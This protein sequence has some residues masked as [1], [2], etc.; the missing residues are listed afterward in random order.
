MDKYRLSEVAKS[1]LKRIYIRG[2]FEFG[3]KQADEYYNAFFERFKLI[4]EQPLLYPSAE[5]IRPGY[6]RSVCG[7][8][9]IYYRIADDNV[10]EIMTI[11]GHQDIAEWLK[12]LEL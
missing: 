10:V 9:S 4:A 1:D 2:L 8:D 3:E 6:R 12:K 7:V 11:I 5:N